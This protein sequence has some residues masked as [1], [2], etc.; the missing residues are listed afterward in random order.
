M[1]VPMTSVVP[2]DSATAATGSA[3]TT[4]NEWLEGIDPLLILILTKS[5]AVLGIL[6][7]AWLA[8]RILKILTAQIQRRFED[9]DPTTVTEFEQR[10]KT[11][12]HLL[13]SVGAATIGVAALLTV[14]NL[15]IPI[16]PLLAGVGVAGL[17]ISFGAQ[18]LVRD[19]INGFFI[20]LEN[21]FAVGDI[22]EING[23]SGVVESITLRVVSVRDVE[24]TVHIIPNGSINMVSNKTKSWARAVLDIG[25]AY[26]ESVDEVIRVVNDVGA[27]LW[28]DADWQPKLAA[29]P[30]VWGVE[31]LAES[32]V[33]VRLI[34]NTRPGKQ[35]QVKREL[36]RRIKNRFDEEG[37]EIPFPQRTLH[38]RGG[39]DVSS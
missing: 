37:I 15:F 34:V 18:S 25:V 13:N 29:A 27:G 4:M 17:A 32:S 20:L 22:I 10:A 24:G 31:D 2:Q 3:L 16:A 21:Q 1:G 6:L 12:I 8:F 39:E 23:K 9:E 26:K 11:L 5:V 28:A 7:G 14:L 38:I 35:W 19:V 36:R 33:N 30:E